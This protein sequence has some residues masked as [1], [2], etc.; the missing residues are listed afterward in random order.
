MEPHI[1]TST[2]VHYECDKCED[3]GWIHYV[4]DGY[5][6]SCP[7]DCVRMRSARKRIEDSGLAGEIKRL[8]FDSYRVYE[9]WQEKIKTSVQGYV[10]KIMEMDGTNERKPWLF[11]GGNSGAGKTHICTAACGKLLENGYPVIYMQWI[12][13]VRRLKESIG[14]DDAYEELIDRYAGAKILYIDDLFKQTT[15]DAPRPTDADVRIAFEIINARYIANLPTIIT[16][17]WHLVPELLSVDEGTF[18]RVYEKT[19]EGGFNFKIARDS[20][21]NMRLRMEGE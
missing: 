11:I 19:K 13:E 21:K 12:P 18:S 7:C 1:E 15:K 8:T 10:D 4:K 3:T 17:E 6:Y 14:D 20:S 2:T 9:P 5:S 16:S